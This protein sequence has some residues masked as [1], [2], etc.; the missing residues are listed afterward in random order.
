MSA[1]RAD[2]AEELRRTRR[3]LAA[4]DEAL[5]D[6]DFGCPLCEYE[7][8]EEEEADLEHALRHSEECEVP[9]RLGWRE[10]ALDYRD[11]R[12]PEWR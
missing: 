10:G 1:I 6:C 5:R 2:L 3:C 12:V 9:V 11:G 8:D 7:P 4:L